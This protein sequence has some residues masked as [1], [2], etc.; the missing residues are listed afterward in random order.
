MSVQAV[1]RL[2]RQIRSL[3]IDEQRRIAREISTA[4]AS[5]KSPPTR[6]REWSELRGAVDSPLT[7]GD[8][9]KWVSEE[10]R[11]ELLHRTDSL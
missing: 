6:R 1:D 3:P 9:Q 7:G 4:L 11:T 2:I 10:R 5:A 8:A